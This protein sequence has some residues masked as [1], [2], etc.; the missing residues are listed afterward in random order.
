MK[1]LALFVIL[2]P[3]I[4]SCGF[5]SMNG[6]VAQGNK[7]NLLEMTEETNSSDFRRAGWGRGKGYSI[8]KID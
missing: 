2:I 8:G 3:F 4:T 6:E 1:R 5:T 7:A